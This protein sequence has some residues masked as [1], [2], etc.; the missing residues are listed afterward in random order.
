MERKFDGCALEIR[1]GKL[2]NLKRWHIFWNVRMLLPLVRWTGQR[3]C[4]TGW[5]S[6]ERLLVHRTRVVPLVAGPH[7]AR[8]HSVGGGRHRHR[9]LAAVRQIRR[10]AEVLLQMLQRMV[11]FVVVLDHGCANVRP[12]RRWLFRSKRIAPLTSALVADH[13]RV[14][15]CVL[16]HF[17]RL[18]RIQ[19]SI[20]AYIVEY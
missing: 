15:M 17:H 4:R 14:Q 5:H 3:S 19:T 7:G 11:R 6:H 9:L 8:E 16:Q 10:L 2:I 13:G 18:V 20:A 1:N 12:V